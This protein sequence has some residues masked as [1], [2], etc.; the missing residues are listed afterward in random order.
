M[1]PS[2][3]LINLLEQL[4]EMR[5]TF[6]LLD[7][8]LMMKGYDSGT[9]RWERCTRQGVGKRGGD[10]ML[11]PG[12]HPFPNLHVH[13]KPCLWGFYGGFITSS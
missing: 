7:H 12:V 10:S 1:T 6:Y 5:E 3:G 2:L 9:A 13:Q 8:P 11:S 4:T